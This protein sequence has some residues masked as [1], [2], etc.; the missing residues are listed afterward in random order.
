MLNI[1]VA[2]AYAEKMHDTT[3]DDEKYNWRNVGAACV[4][5]T[6]VAV[7]ALCNKPGAFASDLGDD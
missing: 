6:C 2:H 5:R 7:T 1:Y 3:L 4:D